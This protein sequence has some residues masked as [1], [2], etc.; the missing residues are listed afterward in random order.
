MET[1]RV[2]APDGTALHAETAG[3]PDS[4]L[5]V[6]FC[7]GWALSRLFWTTQ[8][9]AMARRARVVRYDHRCHGRSADPTDGPPPS[10]PQLGDDLRAVIDALAPTGRLVLVGH[11]MGGMTILAL[12][13]RHPELFADRVAAVGL[14]DTTARAAPPPGARLG[15]TARITGAVMRRPGLIR[16]MRTAVP[17]RRRLHRMM[18][19]RML[20]GTGAPPEAVRAGAEMIQST[21][22]R[23]ITR[24]YPA[25]WA[26]DERAS[27]HRLAGRPILIM[28][29]RKDRLTPVRHARFIATA[30][31]EA[32]FEVL[33][34]RGH[35]VPM[36]LPDL[37][38]ER[39]TTLLDSVTGD[40][41]ARTEEV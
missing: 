40:A 10:L 37:V 22:V 34:G 19:G 39:L 7:H 32:T 11:S 25:L 33:P 30:L 17:P 3:P 5:T 38:T 26:H 27:L 15:S 36:E 1:H 9:E 6:V 12:A 21:T 41:P 20:F 4:P 8:F 2:L 23:T 13:G 16:A 35:M 24:F 18:I 28:V 31:P 29:G 14:F